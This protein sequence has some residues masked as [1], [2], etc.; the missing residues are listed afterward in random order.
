MYKK[1][2]FCFCLA[3]LT[4][5]ALITSCATISALLKKTVSLDRAIQMAAR[6]IEGNV[7]TGQKI[8]LLNFNSPSEQ[9]SEYVL[10][11]LTSELVKG[12]K[13]IVVD[14]RELE[15][16]RQEENFQ[17]S[18]E[19]SDESAQAIGKKLGAQLIVSGSLNAIGSAYRIRIRVLNVETAAIEASPS[20]DIS[21]TEEKVIFLLD[22]KGSIQVNTSSRQTTA[23]V[24]SKNLNRIRVYVAGSYF[25]TNDY[26]KKGDTAC[27]WVNGV[28]TKLPVSEL[29]VP[30]GDI[31]KYYCDIGDVAVSDGKVYV[32]GSYRCDRVGERY[33]ASNESVAACYWVDGVRTDLPVPSGTKG[34][35]AS[36]IVVSGGKIYVAG[37]YGSSVREGYTA[38]YWVD[39]VR[40]E[41]SVPSEAI[42][43][44]YAYGITDIAVS[45]GK[46]YVAGS[47]VMTY[48]SSTPGRT[49]P[50][51]WIDGVRTDL[52]V[53]SGFSGY[54]KAIA[55]L[56]GKAYMV[57]SY[58]MR[59]ETNDW[60]FSGD[61]TACYWVDGVRTDLSIPGE[62][63]GAVTSAIVI[64]GGKVYIAGFYGSDSKDYTAC[65]WVNGVKTDLPVPSETIRSA[66]SAIV[67]SGG[68]VYVAGS[69]ERPSTHDIGSDD[70]ACYWVD[71]VRT[72]LP[73]PSGAT[74]NAKAIAIE[75]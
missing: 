66:T 8:A 38:C 49:T 21:A 17:L 4:V 75:G 60:G 67:V 24:S 59:D 25:F 36:A 13:L 62:T 48:R 5:L 34:Q 53:P 33:S 27:Y 37:S 23:K 45:D 39:G 55:V 69:Y 20:A 1:H 7:K 65:Y 28:E 41:L 35:D 10:A 6:S 58:Y 71:R 73:A 32:A 70:M 18:G 63:A 15:L 72:D 54:A 11:E 56:S 46:V 26:S 51:Y 12:K 74:V 16:I 64:S 47:Y 52:P 9:F 61:Q 42:V 50:C 2:L 29:P 30:S 68:K 19:V 40:T 44:G 22:G 3:F 43:G 14:R 31:T 57:G